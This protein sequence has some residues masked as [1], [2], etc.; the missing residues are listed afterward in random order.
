MMIKPVTAECLAV[1]AM[2]SV[3]SDQ[4]H[5]GSEFL[6]IF[7]FKQY[8]LIHTYDVF[9]VRDIRPTRLY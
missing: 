5:E 4:H 7:Y 1:S 2:D 9:L 3:T 8:H 6:H